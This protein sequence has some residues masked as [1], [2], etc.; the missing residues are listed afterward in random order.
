MM[1]TQKMLIYNSWHRGMRE[2]DLIL[3]PFAAI[4]VPDFSP[5]QLTQYESI[6][7]TSDSDLLSFIYKHSPVPPELDNDVMQKII[8]FANKEDHVSNPLLMV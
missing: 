3:G 4:F 6:L 7:N 1:K 2:A 5:L 8:L